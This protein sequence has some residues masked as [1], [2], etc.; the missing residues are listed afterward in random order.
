VVWVKWLDVLGNSH[1]LLEVQDFGSTNVLLELLRRVEE[2]Q[3]FFIED[4]EE[5]SPKCAQLLLA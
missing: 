1:E 3:E 5:T 2:L 4:F